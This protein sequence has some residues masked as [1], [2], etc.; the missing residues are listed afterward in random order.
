VLFQ[1][2]CCAH[3]CF[4]YTQHRNL[5][6]A[7]LTLPGHFAYNF[8]A[9]LKSSQQDSVVPISMQLSG[10]A[11]PDQHQSLSGFSGEH[12]CIE[13]ALRREA[14]AW[15]GRQRPACDWAAQRQV[16]L[17]AACPTSTH[18]FSRAHRGLVARPQSLRTIHNLHAQPPTQQ[19]LIARITDYWCGLR[20]S[21]VPVP[22]RSNQSVDALITQCLRRVGCDTRRWLQRWGGH[23]FGRTVSER[24][25]DNGVAELGH[26]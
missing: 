14:L 1:G 11:I 12:E 20:R 13:A 10:L 6:R 4:W 9:S 2:T 15:M 18:I 26:S 22:H 3:Y 7:A 24:H 19:V 25:G 8:N 16:L 21:V 17:P 23:I 5:H